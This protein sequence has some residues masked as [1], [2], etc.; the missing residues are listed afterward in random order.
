MATRDT[1]W[2][3]GTPCWA[4]LGADV[5]KARTFYSALFGWEVEQLEPV[6]MG[7]WSA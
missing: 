6:E 4:D 3:A 1:A 5:D 2:S 7:Y